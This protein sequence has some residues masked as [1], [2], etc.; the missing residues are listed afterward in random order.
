MMLGTFLGE[1]TQVTVAGG[2]E[3]TMGHVDNNKGESCGLLLNDEL[4]LGGLVLIVAIRVLY[5]CK[6]LDG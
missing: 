5:P 2:L 3:F 6:N 1:V 4:W